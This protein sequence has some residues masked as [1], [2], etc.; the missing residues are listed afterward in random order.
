ML[1]TGRPSLKSLPDTIVLATIVMT[2]LFATLYIAYFLVRPPLL[3]V[4]GAKAYAAS[5]KPADIGSQYVEGFSRLFIERYASWNVYNFRANR[6]RALGMIE[7]ELGRAVAYESQQTEQ[8]VSI[9]QNARQV[10]IL[11]VEVEAAGDAYWNAVVTYRESN[12]DGGVHRSDVDKRMDLVVRH[13]TPTEAAPY[14]LEVVTFAERSSDPS[15]PAGTPAPA[16]KPEA[17]VEPARPAPAVDVDALL[18]RVKPVLPSPA[19]STGTSP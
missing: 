1:L 6:N 9:L 11:D 19:P 14:C 17:A 2:L 7:A 18:D 15:A 4:R 10:R 12:F 13:I 5:V 16:P 8:L 3:L